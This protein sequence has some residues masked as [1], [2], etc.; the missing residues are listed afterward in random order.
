MR[1]AINKDYAP[2][3]WKPRFKCPRQ[4]REDFNQN[5]TGWK[6][7][8]LFH[9]AGIYFWFCSITPSYT[10]EDEKFHQSKYV[11]KE[12]IVPETW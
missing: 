6:V 2:V 4:S 12:K 8:T 11:G 1:S 7:K 3:H 10:A 5:V 9:T